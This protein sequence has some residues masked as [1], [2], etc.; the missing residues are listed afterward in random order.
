M[1]AP[2]TVTNPQMVAADT[3]HFPLVDLRAVSNGA[4]QWVAL[5]VRLPVEAVSEAAA[6]DVD[7]APNAALHAV[8]DSGDLLAAIAPLDCIIHL[9]SAAPLQASL[10]AKLP[11]SRVMFAV[12]VACLQEEGAADHL[13]SLQEG[14]YRVLVDGALRAP[15]KLPAALRAVAHDASHPLPPG[16]L[17]AAVFGPHL[18]Y[19]VD[20]PA[21]YQACGKAGLGWTSGR[22][23][24]QAKTAGGGAQADDGVTSRR[25]LK[26]LGLLL[27]DAE[28]RDIETELKQHPALCFQLLRLV[29]SAAF[30]PSKPI[31]NFSQA[32]DRLGRRQLLRWLQLLLFARPGSD[33]TANPLLPVAALR[34]AQIESL[35]K[36]NGCERD[37]QDLSFQVGVFSL[38]DLLLGMP[39]GEIVAAL[40]L[41][42]DAAGALLERSGVTGGWLSLAE[43]DAP[44]LA[45]LH[46]SG[47]T[48]AQ[49][50]QS[51]LDGF[52]W[53]IQVSR[54][55]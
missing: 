52:H 45:A 36:Q 11:P 35:C 22:H 32:I 20:T 5:S 41:P 53:A 33:G 54:N 1:M 10:L 8:F 13:A 12:D 48:P 7:A 25:L 24:L 15:V 38:L 37:D 2:I 40:R 4:H 16:T 9:S 26:L 6:D 44:T 21:L 30:A 18:A 23:A 14:G 28:T 51:Q 29:N 47:V 49:W 3:P 50:W 46:S 55:L 42:E 19:H 43:S 17:L 39:M 34:A 31:H 27:A